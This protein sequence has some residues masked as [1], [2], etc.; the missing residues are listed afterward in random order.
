MEGS[1]NYAGSVVV[2]D[3]E[4]VAITLTISDV[5][6]EQ[7]HLLCKSAMIE[8]TGIVTGDG[9][10]KEMDIVRISSLPFRLCH[11]YVLQL[12]YRHRDPR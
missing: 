4:I 9:T 3:D 10:Q 12:V 6:D 11:G 1:N 7:A 2:E 8:A 5:P